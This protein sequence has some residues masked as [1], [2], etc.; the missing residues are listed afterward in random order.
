MLVPLVILAVLSVVGGWIGSSALLV[1]VIDFEKFLAP[2]FQCD[3]PSLNAGSDGSGR[4]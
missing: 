1:V 2:V 4:N 3:T